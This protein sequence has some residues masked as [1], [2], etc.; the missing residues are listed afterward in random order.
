MSESVLVA[1]LGM[2][3]TVV[4]SLLG[5]L[6]SQKLTIYRIQQ[7]ETKVEAHNKVVERTFKLEGQMK[8]CQHEIA[9]LKEYHKPA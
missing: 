9:D 6:T 2:L 5:V 4:G 1:L 7:L 3:G 8:E